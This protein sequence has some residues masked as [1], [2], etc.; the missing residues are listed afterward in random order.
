MI[1]YLETNF[2][3]SIT[4]GREPQANSLLQN[5]P[6]SVKLVMPSIC[7]M[8]AL[9]ALE[10]E[11]KYRRRF[12][13]ELNLQIGQLRRDLLS[14]HARSL[15]ALLTESKTE[16][17]ELLKDIELRLFQALNQISLK[18]EMIELTA[19]MV[20]ESL[21]VP[22]FR[23]DHTDNLILYCILHHAR[24]HPSETKAFLS[25][26]SREFGQAEV[27][28]ALTNAGV[29]NYFSSTQNFI[30]WRQSQSGEE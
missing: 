4:T 19:D 6:S 24:L 28:E 20:K 21:N 17:D 7:L 10:S 25:S 15:L 30:L 18:A 12:E 23:T 3:M 13:N 22:F 5:T 1:L 16:N 29:V 9:S 26:N 11:Q 27:Q 14:S 2:L 8:E